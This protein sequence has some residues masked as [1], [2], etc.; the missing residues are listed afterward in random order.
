MYAKATCKT[1]G[2][3]FLL[4]FG[5]K[6]KEEA[7]QQHEEMKKQGIYCRVHH[8]ENVREQSTDQTGAKE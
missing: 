6:P 4:D 2:K 8:E 3:L 5:R 7:I 1:C